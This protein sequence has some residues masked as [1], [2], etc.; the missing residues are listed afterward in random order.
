L[1]FSFL[2]LK[3]LVWKLLNL[4]H[5]IF[6]FFGSINFWISVLL[7]W[8]EMSPTRIFCRWLFI[9]II[10]HYVKMCISF[11]WLLPYRYKRLISFFKNYIIQIFR[12]CYSFNIIYW[13]FLLYSLSFL[14]FS[15]RILSKNVKP[16]GPFNYYNSSPWRH[17]KVKGF[18][19]K[20]FFLF[21]RKSLLKVH[22]LNL[23]G[24][25]LVWSKKLKK[26]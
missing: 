9:T 25:F 26:K 23:K 19:K 3:R 24:S 20:F 14:S 22:K 7:F 12:L 6:D 10:W 13:S 16:V 15:Y 2:G 17:Y 5:F 4:K 8:K 11:I 21:R 1:A 18:W